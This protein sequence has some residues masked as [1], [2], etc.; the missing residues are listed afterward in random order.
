MPF[1]VP[2]S[3]LP[4]LLVLLSG[5][6][7]LVD[8]VSVLGLG[9]VFTANMTGNVVFLGFALVGT[10]GFAALPLVLSLIGFLA[11]S[12][13][14]GILGRHAAARPLRHWLMR[15]AVIEA[16]LFALAAACAAGPAA[17]AGDGL[18]P[19]IMLT[20]AAMGLRNATVRQLKVPD[21]TTTVVTLTLA[22]LAADSRLAGGH[23]PNLGRRI[24]AVLAIL[25]G[26]AIGAALVSRF[27]L[28]VPLVSA[29]LITVAATALCSLH[30]S[31]ARPHAVE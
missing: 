22:G 23:D 17:R 28:V 31:T 29:G 18:Y 26:A 25:A 16:T 21:L 20:A 6:T 8:A 19:I 1:K 30:S 14:A 4:A 5:V 27:G 9:K 24:A 7:G 12:L 13:A 10:A 15:A 3:P 11:G 2:T